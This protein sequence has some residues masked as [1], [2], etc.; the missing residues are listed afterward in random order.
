MLFTYKKAYQNQQVCLLH[1]RIVN[2]FVFPLPSSFHMPDYPFLL[3]QHN[4]EFRTF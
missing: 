3:L 2:K 4:Y 1:L